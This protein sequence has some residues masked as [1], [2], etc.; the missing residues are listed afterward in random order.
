MTAKQSKVAEASH[1]LVILLRTE[2][3]KRRSKIW[4][5]QAWNRQIDRYQK[6]SWPPHWKVN[7]KKVSTRFNKPE[8]FS[9][10]QNNGKDSE[11]L[12]SCIILLILDKKIK[13]K[14]ICHGWVT[15]NRVHYII[16]RFA[17]VV[18]LAF[19][20]RT[21]SELKLTG[22]LPLNIKNSFVKSRTSR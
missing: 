13:D 12:T 17:A 2:H 4:T 14:N 10:N 16:L 19:V 5:I 15:L 7:H 8:S 20:H 6:K 9:R 22:G 18:C 21:Q 1:N 3:L 11:I